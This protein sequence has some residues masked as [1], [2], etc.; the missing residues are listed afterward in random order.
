[1]YGY[2][3]LPSSRLLT[4]SFLAKESS[5]G[6]SLKVG[7]HSRFMFDYSRIVSSCSGSCMSTCLIIDFFSTISICEDALLFFDDNVA[8]LNT[9]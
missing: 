2:I 5:F 7:E 4:S 3:V 6:F 1:M 8:V 9:S